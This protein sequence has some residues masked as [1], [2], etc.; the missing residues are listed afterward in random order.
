M[1]LA[2]FGATGG[3]GQFVVNEALE[4]GHE[5]TAMARRPDAIAQRH[6]KLTVRKTDSNDTADL[7]AAVAGHDVVISTLGPSKMFFADTDVYSGASLN[8]VRAM[9]RQGVRRL[10]AVTSAGTEDAR[11]A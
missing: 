2:I 1:K 9:E 11:A 3:T 4:R 8:V 10:I 6:P 5:V 7:D